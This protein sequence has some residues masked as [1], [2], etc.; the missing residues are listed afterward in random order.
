MTRSRSNQRFAK[1]LPLVV[2]MVGAGLTAV[3]KRRDARRARHELTDPVT[4]TGRALEPPLAASGN[5][6]AAST[7]SNLSVVATIDDP[8]SG[9]T[10]QSTVPLTSASSTPTSPVAEAASR[11]RGATKTV[12]LEALAENGA[13]TAVEVA[14]ATG[15]NR[16]TVSSTLSRLAK[17]GEITKAER[18]YQL[19]QI[20][21]PT[22]STKARVLH[23]LSADTGLTATD[24]ATATGISRG[25]VSTTL[26]RL[27]KSGEIVKAERGYRLPDRKTRPRRARGSRI[28]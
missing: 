1:T 10:G 6:K 26:S 7:E 16:A 18:G 23:A 4:T 13:M 14:L 20:A 28:K 15:I 22:G 17:A 24:V 5:G 12:V 9:G 11:A 27:A 25:T 19:P 21:A 2:V 8:G 3:K